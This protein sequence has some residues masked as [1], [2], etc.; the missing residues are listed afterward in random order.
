MELK[1][2][3]TRRS[4]KVVERVSGELHEA[5][6]AY[7]EGY[8]AMHGEAIKMWAVVV[9]ILRAFLEADRAFRA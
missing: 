2:I 4:V 3:R 7:A 9:R 6:A 5:L 1:R 8:R